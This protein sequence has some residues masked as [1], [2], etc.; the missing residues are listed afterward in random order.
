MGTVVYTVLWPCRRRARRSIGQSEN[1]V[2]PSANGPSS[3]KACGFIIALMLVFE[4]QCV[5]SITA[6]PG[7][8]RRNLG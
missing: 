6:A 3:E 1:L 4:I 2:G 8:V 7:H 5:C